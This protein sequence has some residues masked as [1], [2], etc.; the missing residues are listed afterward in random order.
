MEARSRNH[1]CR[2][3]AITINYYVCVWSFLSYPAYKAHL[4]C[5]ALY[6]CLWPVWLYHIFP[7]YLI[8]DTILA[9]KILDIK[10]V[11]WFSLHL[12]SELFFILRRIKRDTCTHALCKALIILERFQWNLNFLDRGSKNTQI[13]N[14]MKIRQVGAELFHADRQTDGQGDRMTEGQKWRS[15]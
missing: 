5:A 3:K 9:K 15:W 11:F 2:W 6:C 1:C 13:S 10:F 4:F 8:N 12:L 14:F 7:H